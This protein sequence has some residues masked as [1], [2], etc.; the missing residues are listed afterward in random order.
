MDDEFAGAT[1]FRLSSPPFTTGHT[2]PFQQGFACP[3]RAEMIAL[4]AEWSVARAASIVEDVVKAAAATVSSPV[5]ELLC[6]RNVA[7]RI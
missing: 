2:L 4:A 7:E 5:G 1:I 6:R 3:A